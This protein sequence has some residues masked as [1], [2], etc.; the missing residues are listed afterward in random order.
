MNIIARITLIISS[1]ITVLAQPSTDIRINQIG[2]YTYGPKIAAIINSTASTYK[3]KS[4]DQLTEYSSGTLS[5]SVLWDQSG[6]NVK[7]ADF[8]NFNIPGSY[9]LVVDGLGYSQP[10]AIKEQIFVPL[11]KAVIKAFYYN[12]SSTAIDTKYAGVYARAEGHPDNEIFVH[13]AAA[14]VKRPAGTIIS[15][16]KGWYDAGDYNSYIVNSGISTYSLL[17]S[18]EHFKE[19]YDTLNLNIPES[20]NTL[21]DIL[22]EIK[23]NLD[24][25]LTM[26][27]PNDGGIYNKKTN[28]VF[29]PFVMPADA[30]ESRYVVQKSTSSA[31]DFAAVMAVAYRLYKN[32]DLAYANSC[33]DA[34]KKSYAWGVANPGIYFTNPPAQ[35]GYPAVVT[36]GYGDGN[37]TDELEWAGNELYIATKDDSYY[38]F[39]N[40]QNYGIPNWSNV[41]T[42]GLFSLVFNRKNL[43][44][45][46][47][48]D[49]TNAMNKLIT[50][51]DKF[52]NYQNN[53][54]PYKMVMGVNGNS[55]FTWGSSS[56]AA[57]EGMILLNAYFVNKNVD[58]AK[59]VLSQI[60]YIM[61]RNAT[62]YSF[63][64][65]FG[66]KKVMNIHHRISAADG[67]TDPV[68]GWVVGGPSGSTGDGCPNN[69]TYLA[70]SFTDL[71][72]CYTKVEVAINWNAPAVYITGALEFY[73]IFN[74]PLSVDGL[75]SFKENNSAAINI[76]PVPANDKI[77]IDL[78]SEN[79]SNGVLSIT[80]LAGSEYYKQKININSGL[81]EFDVSVLSFNE[82]FYIVKI[83]S[84]NQIFIKKIVVNKN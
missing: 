81:N 21:P 61:G 35:G 6:E 56:Q 18:Y 60:D 80:D 32:F 71:Q 26:Q 24:W 8:S 55:D 4:L 47:F 25:M 27:D 65:G 10:F 63:V 33:L 1:F 39:N 38:K 64:T 5:P 58:Y 37:V 66:S 51:A 12:R 14:S 82:G 29:D 67:I 74:K 62:G 43:T 49:S 52:K 7:T 45:K 17:A 76:Y 19:Y 46:G 2:F 20:K 59:A 48:A 36:G 70:K 16:P 84:G 3:I 23:W 41:R 77:K 30:I 54:S 72:K 44:D 78:T 57:N 83:E 34:A 11:N 68:P 69:T 50:L 28:A 31:C 13:A 15:C 40:A 73:K 79:N 42:L 75:T 22:D 53:T 9:L